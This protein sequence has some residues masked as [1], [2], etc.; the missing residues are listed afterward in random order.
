MKFKMMA[1]TAL[2]T[3][4]L[5]AGA[6]VAQTP[7]AQAPTATSAPAIVSNANNGQAHEAG[8]KAPKTAWGAPDLQGF[9]NNTSITSMQRSPDAKSLALTQAQAD[10]LVNRN[11][12]IVLTKEDNATNGQ[13]PHNTKVLED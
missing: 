3:A 4:A 7:A 10:R 11:I 5:F 2:G 13:D 12:L 6:A 9:W 1:A 8:Y